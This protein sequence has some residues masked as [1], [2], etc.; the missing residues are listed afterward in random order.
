MSLGR[1]DLENALRAI[2]AAKREELGEPP[3]PEEL[4]AYRDGRLDAAARQS[5]EARLALYPDA[6]RA[7][8]DLA[9]FPEVEPAPGTPEL[10]DEDV[11][12]RWMALREKLGEVEKPLIPGPSGRGEPPPTHSG[13]VSPS[14]GSA[15]SLKLAAG[16]LLALG[17]GFLAGRASHPDPEG[18]VNVTI[19][20]LTPVEEG[21]V[22]AASEVEVSEFSEELVLVLGL[23]DPGE[24]PDYE[25]EI[26]DPDGVRRWSRQGLRPTPLGTFHLGFRRD[27]L[28]PG[29][30]QV[31]LFGLGG[32]R[33]TRLATYDLRLA[34]DSEGD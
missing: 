20:E 29:S 13:A 23:L 28:P 25:A 11:E 16:A 2:M 10:S 21:G 12:A 3:T 8:A 5:V 31:L 34:E 22:R 18:A 19:A 33:R 17:V 14:S 27:V 1:E 9:A 32:D 6:A 7:L 24:Y 4:L 30:Y 26:L 15:S